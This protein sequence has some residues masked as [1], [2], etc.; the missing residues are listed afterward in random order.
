MSRQ[1]YHDT[2]VAKWKEAL[3]ASE[4]AYRRSLEKS[5]DE[6]IRAHETVHIAEPKPAHIKANDSYAPRR[7]LGDVTNRRAVRI[8]VP[9]IPVASNATNAASGD[10]NRRVSS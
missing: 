4:E 6:R 10:G 7:V 3:K 9:V 5:L 8:T 2:E 1:E